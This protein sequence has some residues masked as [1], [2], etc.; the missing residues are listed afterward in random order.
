MKV[1][2]V[3]M[4]IRAIGL[5]SRPGA[6]GALSGALSRSASPSGAAARGS[7][8]GV[9]VVESDIQV[10]LIRCLQ[11]ELYAAI[12]ALS[13]ILGGRPGGLRSTHGTVVPAR[14]ARN[15]AGRAQGARLR[16]MAPC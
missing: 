11:S 16:R 9:E 15:Y 13:I 8:A 10:L 3:V 1:S 2:G 14:W 4:S 7:S 5:S 6:S 12:V